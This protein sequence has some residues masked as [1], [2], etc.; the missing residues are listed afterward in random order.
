MQLSKWITRLLPWPEIY[1]KLNCCY[2]YLQLIY[3]VH[4]FITIVK[5][6]FIVPASQSE[7]SFFHDHH[8]RFWESKSIKFWNKHFFS[9]MVS[10][11]DVWLL[12]HK[13]QKMWKSNGQWTYCTLVCHDP[14]SVAP[15]PHT[16]SREPQGK[17]DGTSC[18]HVCYITLTAVVYCSRASPGI[19]LMANIK[20]ASSIFERRDVGRGHLQWI[21]PRIWDTA[22]STLHE[23]SLSIMEPL[24]TPWFS[25]NSF[26]PCL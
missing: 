10:V 11:L 25:S 20:A 17:A 18:W 24:N 15:W 22:F 14:V 8:E 3:L 7:R 4:K 1:I 23:C 19:Q 21:P 6:C 9:D 16:V 5:P 2:G 13:G 26:F 12:M